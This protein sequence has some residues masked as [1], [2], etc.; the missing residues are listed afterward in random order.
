MNCTYCDTPLKINRRTQEYYCPL[1]QKQAK[2]NPFINNQILCL[3]FVQFVTQYPG[4]LTRKRFKIFE[5]IGYDCV[6]CGMIGSHIVWWREY[7]KRQVNHYTLAGYKEGKLTMIT[8]DHI[9]PKSR[10]G[11]DVIGNYQPMCSPCNGKK[12]DKIV[13]T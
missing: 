1:E 12:S 11:L 6:S 8:V 13:T 4:V 10:G 5:Q 3:P 7:S 9:F 2:Q